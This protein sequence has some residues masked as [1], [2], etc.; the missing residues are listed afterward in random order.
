MFIRVVFYSP[1]PNCFDAIVAL[2]DDGFQ[3]VVAAPVVVDFP[4]PVELVLLYAFALPI[5]VAAVAAAPFDHSICASRF[6]QKQGQNVQRLLLV[7]QVQ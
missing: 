3:L 2:A 7:L 6:E 5:A 4:F 1:T